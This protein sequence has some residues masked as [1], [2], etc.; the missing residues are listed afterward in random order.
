MILDALSTALDGI[1][2]MVLMCYR[3]KEN[4]IIEIEISFVK[5]LI[6]YLQLKV[7]VTLDECRKS[8]ANIENKS[9]RT[10]CIDEVNL[11]YTCIELLLFNCSKRNCYDRSIMTVISEMEFREEKIALCL[12]YS[13][14]YNSKMYKELLMCVNVRFL[15]LRVEPYEMFAYGLPIRVV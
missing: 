12:F 6:L 10:I 9:N 3:M 8:L 7:Q 11:E 15:I 14:R 4:Q 2:S 1:F 13:G 5:K